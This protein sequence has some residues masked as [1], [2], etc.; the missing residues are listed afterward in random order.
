MNKLALLF[1]SE[2][3]AEL[4]QLLFGLTPAR[5]YRAEIVRRTHFAQASVE[6]ELAKLVRLE[7]LTTTTDGNRRYYAANTAHP[8]FPE[9]R[10]I[11]L[12]TSGLRDLLHDA[13]RAS[14]KIEYA[15]VFGSLA[16]LRERAE[17]DLDLMVIGAATHRD[18]ASPLRALAEKLAREVNP[19]FLTTTELLRRLNARD[20]SLSEVVAQPKLFIIGDEHEFADMVGR[21]LA[22]ATP[23][24]P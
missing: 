12:K 16:D 22:P 14:K 1:H 9:L 19:H 17:S 8:L 4:L 21:G 5:L 24:Q 2:V 6:E 18:L 23:H 3:R 11:V 15:F 7:L 20:H 10:N 13:L